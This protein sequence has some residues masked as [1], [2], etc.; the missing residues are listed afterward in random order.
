MKKTFTNRAIFAM[1]QALFGGNGSDGIIS[2][3]NLKTRM[4]VRQALKFNCISVAKAYETISKMILEINKELLNGFVEE[5]KAHRDDE[6]NTTVPKDYVKEFSK[7]QQEKLNELLAQK[8]DIDITTIPELEFVAYAKQNDGEL[9]DLEL[10]MLEEF[11]H[12]EKHE[13]KE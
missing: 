8:V 2:K 6:G 11:V 9:T 13:E 12:H 5:G 4:A 1:G 3:K 10:D 7:K